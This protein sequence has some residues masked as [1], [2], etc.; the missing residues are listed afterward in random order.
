[1]KKNFSLVLVFALLSG[2]FVAAACTSH[3]FAAGDPVPAVSV[4]LSTAG[5]GDPIPPCPKTTGCTS[6]QIP[7]LAQKG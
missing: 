1:M 3:V 5:A 2:L 7:K 4:P 6:T